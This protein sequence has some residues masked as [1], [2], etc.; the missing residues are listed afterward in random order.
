MCCEYILHAISSILAFYFLIH[1]FFD[2]SSNHKND[3]SV[4]RI[5]CRRCFLNTFLKIKNTLFVH[6]IERS[7]VLW[8]FAS[9]KRMK[10][11]SLVCSSIC[12]L[13]P[14]FPEKNDQGIK[15][16]KIYIEVKKHM[17]KRTTAEGLNANCS[18]CAATQS[19]VL[20]PQRHSES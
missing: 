9:S 20:P 17:N 13:R 7:D 15:G 16:M 18:Y 2:Q 14:V 1:V 19:T 8:Y 5:W 10:D 3:L 11:F 12:S 4:F 6:S